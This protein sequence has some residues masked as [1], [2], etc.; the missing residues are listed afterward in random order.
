M[1]HYLYYGRIN[2][3]RGNNREKKKKTITIEDYNS[4]LNDLICKKK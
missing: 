1:A 2:Y 3:I 4:L